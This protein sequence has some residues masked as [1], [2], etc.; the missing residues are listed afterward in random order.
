MNPPWGGKYTININTEMNYWPAET[1]A[2]PECEQPLFGM[3]RDLS[4]TGA[5]TAQE[6][7]GAHGWVCHHNT[8]LWRASAPIDGAFWGLWPTGGAWLTTMLWQHYLFSGDKKFLASVYPVMKGSCEFFLDTLVEEPAHHW[9]VTCPSVSPEHA[10][11]DNTS[12]CDGPTM[13]EAILRDLFG[14]TAE[15]A[16]ILGKD[17]TFAQELLAKRARL[18]PYQIGKDG[19]LQEW[20][21]DWDRQAPDIHHRHMS[22]LYGLFPSDQITAAEPELMA[23]ARKLMEQR[24]DDGGMGW[25]QA[26]RAALWAR[27]PDG[28]KAYFFIRSLLTSWTESNLFD[29]PVAQLDGNFGG[30]AAIAEM[31]LQSQALESQNSNL[32]YEID[33]L[34]ALPSA[35]PNGSSKGLYARGGF[36]VSETWKDGKLTEAAV[37]SLLGNPVRLKYG[38]QARE[39]SLKKGAIFQ[40][41]GQ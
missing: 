30:T 10:H 6:M 25:A 39:L 27:M 15:A 12:I 37:Q 2:L 40:W 3:I 5:R 7:Y 1:C 33:L 23:A 22:P 38:D 34:P 9:L 32:K 29:R 14:E 18:A 36:V 17:K 8:D 21:Q 11:H 24:G 20:L 26:W 35:W 31:L 41:D 13:D 4:H 19:Q 28:D 16:R